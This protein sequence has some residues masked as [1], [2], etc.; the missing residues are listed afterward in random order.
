MIATLLP[1][2]YQALLGVG[3]LSALTLALGAAFW[4]FLEPRLLHWLERRR[5]RREVG[6]GPRL[7]IRRRR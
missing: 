5:A 2:I 3:L 1:P 6:P 7:G 4:P